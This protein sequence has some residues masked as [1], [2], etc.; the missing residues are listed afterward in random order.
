MNYLEELKNKPSTKDIQREIVRVNVGIKG[1]EG[2]EDDD[3]NDDNKPSKNVSVKPTANIPIITQEIDVNYNR[4]ALKQKILANKL[5]KITAKTNGAES[6]APPT[7]TPTPT[8]TTIVIE[9]KVVDA[10]EITE[11][12][13][14]PPAKLKKKI[15]LEIERDK[16]ELETS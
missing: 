15:L 11:K 13:V 10:T 8:P 1:N 4:D 3:D 5:S 16:K 6:R 9:P 12:K 14:P 2:N 7:P